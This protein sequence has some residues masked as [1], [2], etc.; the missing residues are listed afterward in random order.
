[1]LRRDMRRMCTVA[2]L[3]V[4]ALI[5]HRAAVAAPR[6]L[7]HAIIFATSSELTRRALLARGVPDYVPSSID[8]FTRVWPR[9]REAVE[10]NWL[11]YLDGQGTRE[12]AIDHL[13]SAIPR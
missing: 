13:V 5:S 10:K 7:W 1:M 4:S 11:P 9:Y 2:G 8:L 3:L 12:D 6:D